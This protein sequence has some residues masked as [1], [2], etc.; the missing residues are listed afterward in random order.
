MN[1]TLNPTAIESHWKDQWKT[2]ELA[3]KKNSGEPY[4]VMLPPPNVTGS[5]HMGHGF[6]QTLMDILI[7]SQHMLGKKTHWQVGTDHAGIATQMLV[8]RRLQKEEGKSRHDLGRKA[9]LDKI[10]EWKNYSGDRISEQMQRLGLHVD[11]SCERFTM[12]EHLTH[13]TREAFIRLHEKGLIYRGQRLV[14][15]DPVLKTAVS[16]LEVESITRDGH[17][18]HI[19][20]PVVGQEDTYIT[21]ATTRPETM[22]ADV[23]VA[24]HPDDARYQA[25][26]GSHLKLP[27]SGREIPVITDDSVEQDFGSGCVKITPAHDFNDYAMGQRHNLPTINMLTLDCT[28]NEEVP[29]QY[30]GL[31]VADARKAVLADLEEQ[32]FLVSI[33][34]HTLNVPTGDRSGAVLEPLLTL[35]WFVKM[36]GLAKDGLA[37]VKQ[38]DAQFIPE[39]WKK[40][41]DLW[42]ENIQDW[43]ISRQLWWGHRIPAWY[44]ENGKAYV[45]H[46]EADVR[47]RHQL[48]DSITLQQDEDVL[49]TWFSSSLWPFATL[50][51]PEQT[52]ELDT[53]FPTGTLVTGFDIIFFWVA[54]MIM[55]SLALT[56]K[57]PFK[58]IYITGLIRDQQGQ[59]MSKT[60]GNVLDPIDLIDGIEL[61]TLVEKRVGGLI[62]PKQAKAI[63]KSTRKE[64]P[65][66][67]PAFGTDA[68]RLT[69]CALATTGR[70]INFDLARTEGYRHFCNKLWNATRFVGLQLG[71]ESFTAPKPEHQ[72]LADQWIMH[73]LQNTLTRCDNALAQYRFDWLQQALYE[74]TWHDFCDWYLELSKIT[75]NSDLASAEQKTATRATLARVITDLIARLHPI[76]P[77]VTESLWQH[78]R[79]HY[80]PISNTEYVIQKSMPVA[81]DAWKNTNAEDSMTLLQDLITHI[82]RLRSESDIS[83][84]KPI[85]IRLYAANESAKKT[86]QEH[87]SLWRGLTKISDIEW[88]SEE[89]NSGGCACANAKA[90]IVTVPLKGLIDV[91]KA[92]DRLDKQIA[93]LIKQRDT[94]KKKCDNP[95]YCDNAPAEIVAKEKALLAESNDGLVRLNAQRETIT[96]LLG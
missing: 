29:S 86:L 87:E 76:I 94:A 82:R 13:A 20:Y 5:L 10:W 73:R 56:G 41:Y 71:D 30:Q 58:D 26:V 78:M 92:L 49:D 47:S 66:G 88:L 21:I 81:S 37:A 61:E 17:L 1:E 91:D 19:R 15:W 74:F 95:R 57:V 90:A 35:Q 8:E 44:D 70:D 11:W 85:A 83:P 25:L 55:M 46:D 14:N 9:F 27:L 53:Y 72:S 54:R 45:G 7:R 38:G 42:L 24:V 50:G 48:D 4:C 33:E 59:K 84:K 60:K 80:T 65:D 31:S 89:D 52:P 69:Y 77:Y 36:D 16:D 6:Q 32:G 62:N 28:L 3:Q 23:A 18:W 68:L 67:I 63:E 43:C 2:H 75:L 40:T 34:K 51:W 64:F 79:P 12:D 93:K 96:L 22:L 39:N